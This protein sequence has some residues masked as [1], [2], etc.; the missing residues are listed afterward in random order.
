MLRKANNEVQF[1]GDFIRPVIKSDEMGLKGKLERESRGVLA[2]NAC[3]AKVGIIHYMKLL[4]A[5][6]QRD[7]N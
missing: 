2:L 7:S 6:Y 5:L 1:N 3:L 4:T